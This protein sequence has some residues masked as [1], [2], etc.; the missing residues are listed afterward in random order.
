MLLKDVIASS[1]TR[2][3]EGRDY[4]VTRNLDGSILLKPIKNIR[5]GTYLKI[6]D[7]FYVIA[8]VGG[9]HVQLTNARTGARWADKVEVGDQEDIFSSELRD[10]VGESFWNKVE[11]VG[12]FDQ[13][14]A[15]IV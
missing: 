2:Y 3:F 1:E 6:Y 4:S 7:N 13:F 5:T 12:T 14:R 10:L 11:Y 15:R 8:A 9:T